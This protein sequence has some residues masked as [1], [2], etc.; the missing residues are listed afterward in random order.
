MLPDVDL[1]GVARDHLPAE[2]AERWIG[3]LR[4]GIRLDTGDD[5]PGVVVGYLGGTPRMPADMPWPEWPGHGPLSFIAA[6]DCAAL[7]AFATEV[8]WPDSGTLLFFYFEGRYD[9]AEALV[10]FTDPQ[11]QAGAR[12][13]YV[14]AATATSPRAVPEGLTPYVEVPLRGSVA[15]TAPSYDH[16]S[17]YDAFPEIDDSDEHPVADDDFV[18]AL[19]LGYQ[20]GHQLGGYALPVQGPVEF[21]V[22]QV[23]LGGADWDSP[24]LGVEARRWRLLAQIDSDSRAGMTWGDVGMLYWLITDEDLEACRF[25]RALFT[26]QCT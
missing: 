22:A 17:V 12:V 3:L 19:D 4:P 5:A 11:S 24:E 6:V 13:L 2:M 25:D 9:D 1:A 10:I 8:G 20:V 26:W 7:P 21:E 18:D 16:I 14:P 23:A 15:V